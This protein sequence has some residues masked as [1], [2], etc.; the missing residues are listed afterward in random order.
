MRWLANVMPLVVGQLLVDP[1]QYF[2]WGIY[3]GAGVVYTA[4]VFRGELSKEGAA[5]LSKRNARP[6]SWIFAAHGAILVI[7][8]GVMRVVSLVYPSLPNWMTELFPHQIPPLSAFD[9]VFVVA[10]IGLSSVESRWLYVESGIQPH[11]REPTSAE[12]SAPKKE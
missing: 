9:I 3:A 5:I 6:H 7:L 11:D 12:P 10:M 4:L 8:L 2:S 1:L